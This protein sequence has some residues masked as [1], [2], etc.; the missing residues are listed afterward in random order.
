MVATGGVHIVRAG[1]GGGKEGAEGGRDLLVD[2]LPRGGG[3]EQEGGQV[4]GGVGGHLGGVGAHLATCAG[5]ELANT[6]LVLRNGHPAE[7]WSE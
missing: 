3:A 4:K 2:G 1:V 5:P 6:V 7:N